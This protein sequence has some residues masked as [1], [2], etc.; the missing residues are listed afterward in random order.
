MVGENLL[1]SRRVEKMENTGEKPRVMVLSGFGINCE[2]ETARAFE[3][4]GASPRIVHAT[5]LLSDP[6]SLSGYDILAIPG[7]FSFGDDLGS[8]KVLGNKLKSKM[9]G[10]IVDFIKSGKLAIGICNGFQVLVKMG[11]L[12]AADGEYLSQQATVTYNDSGRFEDRWVYLKANQ[13]SKC[14]FTRGL[15]GRLYLPV[16]H[17]EGKFLPASNDLLEKMFVAGQVALQYTDES[18]NLAGYPYNPNG[19]VQNIAGICDPTGRVFGMMPHP[20]A[21]LF[22]ENHPRFSRGG[23]LETLGL[24]IFKN[25]VSYVKNGKGADAPKA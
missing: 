21:Y 22:R 6:Q 23:K 12:P 16:R 19:S 18:G 7:G 1:I 9:S 20:E 10:E 11:L 2:H 4:A 3:M 8:G 25:A 5:A 13:H 17:G 14:V 15:S 24:E